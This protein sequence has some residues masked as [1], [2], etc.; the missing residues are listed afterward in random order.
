M[1][2]AGFQCNFIHP[3]SLEATFWPVILTTPFLKGFSPFLKMFPL[4][5]N[6]TKNLAA[7]SPRKCY[8]L[9]APWRFTMRAIIKALEK[10]SNKDSIFLC[11]IQHSQDLFHHDSSRANLHPMEPEFLRTLGT[12][13]EMTILTWFKNDPIIIWQGLMV[14]NCIKHGSDSTTSYQKF[15]WGDLGC[16]CEGGVLGKFYP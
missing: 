5:T 13:W 1:G 16:P 12:L 10:F 14:S 3:A 2:M 11:S 15:S 4:N 9:D 7:K 6:T 8:M